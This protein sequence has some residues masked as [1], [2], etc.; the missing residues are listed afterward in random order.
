[1]HLLACGGIRRGFCP[2]CGVVRTAESAALLVDEVL[3]E[4][5]LRQWTLSSAYPLRLV[6]ASRPAI[7][8][9]VLGVTCQHL[10]NQSIKKAV[11]ACKIAQTDATTL[12]QRP[13][14]ALNLNIHFPIASDNRGSVNARSLALLPADPDLTGRSNPFRTPCRKWR[15]CH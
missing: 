2:G 11:S 1:M 5:P 13:G 10:A 6:T 9:Q 7:M 4:Q 15:I 14:G 12:I 3:P 8:G